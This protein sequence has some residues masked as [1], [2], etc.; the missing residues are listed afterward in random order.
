M[1]IPQSSPT[2]SDDQRFSQLKNS[3][4]KTLIDIKS[5]ITI[6]AADFDAIA[7]V[8]SILEPM[9]AA[10]EA[11][12]SCDATL[13]STYVAFNVMLNIISSGTNKWRLQLQ[14]VLV[15]RRNE[16]RTKR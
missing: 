3:V 9:K 14:D 1:K 15:L 2:K 12:C 13:I 8:G 11:L 4:Q 7:D 10:V 5:P 6:T 16:R